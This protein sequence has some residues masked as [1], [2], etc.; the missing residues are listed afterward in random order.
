MVVDAREAFLAHVALWNAG[1]RTAW[2]QLFTDDVTFDDPVGV[3]TKHGRAALET[4][5]ERSNQPGRSWR[6]E[7][8]RAVLCGNECA[9]DLMNHGSL[10]GI[11]IAVSSIEIWR[12]NAHGFVDSVRVYFEP[13]AQLNDPY[14]LPG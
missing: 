3:P 9:V 13:D 12:A 4:S 11:D 7:P 1:D 10:D 14:Y 6:L 5:W 8:K 2:L